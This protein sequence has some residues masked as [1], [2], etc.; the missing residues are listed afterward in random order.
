MRGLPAETWQRRLELLDRVIAFVDEAPAPVPADV[1][2]L[3]KAL[4]IIR[5]R[6]QYAVTLARRQRRGG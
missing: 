5:R 1:V 2:W 6:A 4:L 3:R